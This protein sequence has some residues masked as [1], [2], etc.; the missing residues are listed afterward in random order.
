MCQ[1]N[2]TAFQNTGTLTDCAPAFSYVNAVKSIWKFK[3]LEYVEEIHKLVHDS[4]PQISKSDARRSKRSFWHFFGAATIEDVQILQQNIENLQSATQI[5]LQSFAHLAEKYSSFMNLSDQ[6]LQNLAAALTKQTA[7]TYRN[8]RN[9]NAAITFLFSLILGHSD[10]TD[11]ALLLHH[12]EHQIGELLAGRLPRHLITPRMLA[13]VQG[14][15]TRFLKQYNVPLHL[16]HQ[17]IADLYENPQFVLSRRHNKIF[18][19]MH[20]PLSLTSLPM[21][22]YQITALKLPTDSQNQHASFITNLPPYVAYNPTQDWFLEFNTMPQISKASLYL[23]Q[24][25]PT[26]LKHR[27]SPTCFLAVMQLDR[28]TI[29]RL[30]QFAIQPYAAAP[31]IFILGDGKLLI[32]F[33]NQYTLV[34]ANETQIHEGCQLCVIQVLCG[35]KFVAGNYQYFAKIAHCH[36]QTAA[37]NTV[38]YA[39]NV[40]YLHQYFNTSELIPDNQELLSFNPHI[41]LPNLTFQEAQFTESL[42]LTHQIIV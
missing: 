17:D 2:A 3:N 10:F 35:C 34:C 5:S 9:I 1:S 26:A 28:E 21:N 19:T 12:F 4:I 36:S 24:H 11:A 7:N 22:L 27:T 38:K 29:Q 20:F 31:Q 23:L 16:A 18:I 40:N 42:G 15:I 41:F 37:Q 30:C 32:Q 13:D 8:L 14:N 25:N 39:V 33:L 6:N